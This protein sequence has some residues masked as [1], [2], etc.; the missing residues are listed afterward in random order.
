[1]HDPRDPTSIGVTVPDYSAGLEKD[2][3]GLTI[4]VEEDYFFRDVDSP[5]EQAVRQQIDQL[6][7]Q[8]ATLKTV[9]IP[10]LR[11]SEW[12]EL[13]TSLSEASAIH[14]TDLQTR[15]DDFGADIRFLFELGEIGRAHV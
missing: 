2:P 9:K 7:N 11:H 3:K 13:A 10:S 8:G 1:G 15:P 14:H 4:G 5:I 6:V 12:A